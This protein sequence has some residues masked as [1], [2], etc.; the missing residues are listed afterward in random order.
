MSDIENDSDTDKLTDNDS[1]IDTTE[2]N[3]IEDDDISESENID[4]NSNI[5]NLDDLFISETSINNTQRITKPYLTKY[6]KVRIL[7]LRTKQLSLGAKPLVK[8]NG[9][10]EPNKIALLEYENNMIP[11][12]IKRP[13]PNGTFEIWKF[14]ELQN[15]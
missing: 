1:N 9:F 2:I 15:I 7:G 13:L 12:K 10:L 4:D 8:L 5:E 11:F 14:S 6:E 3:E